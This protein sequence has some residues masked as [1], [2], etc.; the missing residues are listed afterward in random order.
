MSEFLQPLV[1]SLQ[2][3]M[4]T[5]VLLFIIAIP[6]VY[7]IYFHSGSAKPLFK[8]VVS[9]PLVLPPTVLGYYLLIFMRPD[10]WLGQLSQQLFDLRLVFSFPGLV[11]GSLIFSLPF[12]VNPILSAIENLPFSYKEA[13]YTLGKSRWNTLWHVLLPN[14]RSS[15]LVGLVMTFA[16]TIGEFG[17]ILMIG[18][19][20]PGETRVASIAIYNEVEMLNFDNAD[21]Y[22]GIL[23][24]FSFFVLISVYI[25]Q[26]RSPQ[27]V[28]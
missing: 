15:V 28:I 20:I 25:Y 23:L 26:N 6:L 2:L 11:I 4:A 19:N 24:A 9:M 8:A 14:V 7:A 13:A 10:G 1:L 27:G 3:A 17:V 21:M 18:G 12:M 16:H 5:T 22:A